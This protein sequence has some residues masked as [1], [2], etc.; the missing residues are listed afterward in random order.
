MYNY[1]CLQLYR[2]YHFTDVSL[3]DSLVLAPVLNYT[4]YCFLFV[5]PCF[6]SLLVFSCIWPKI[7]ESGVFILSAMSGFRFLFNQ[8]WATF[9]FTCLIRWA[10]PYLFGMKQLVA[11]DTFFILAFVNETGKP[12]HCVLN[13]KYYRSKYQRSSFQ[14][15]G[16][17][18]A[19]DWHGSHHFTYTCSLFKFDF[20][21]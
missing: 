18:L 21:C 17:H 14:A 20:Q 12:L 8:A 2:I 16:H 6:F 9:D 19:E 10:W 3:A 7:H 11:T 5:V 13:T 1:A 4:T 15:S